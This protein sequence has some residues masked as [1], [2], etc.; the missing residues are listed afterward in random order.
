MNGRERAT[1]QTRRVF[2][3]HSAINTPYGGLLAD[4]RRSLEDVGFIVFV[5]EHEGRYGSDF[6]DRIFAELETCSAAVLLL[7]P[8]AMTSRW[9]TTEINI[10]MA[11]LRNDP[12]RFCVLPVLLG[13]ATLATLRASSVGH[14]HIDNLLMPQQPT[15]P[16]AIV[17]ELADRHPSAGPLQLVEATVAQLLKGIDDELLGAAAA[18]LGVQLRAWHP[19]GKRLAMARA[20][21]TVDERTFTRALLLIRRFL[22]DRGAVVDLVFPFLWV[23]PHAVA[24]LAKAAESLDDRGAFSVNARRART[25]WWYVRRACT[26][27]EGW[28]VVDS[29]GRELED[30]DAG[31]IAEVRDQLVDQVKCDDDVDDDTLRASLKRFEEDYGPIFV[32]L[33]ESVDDRL[34]ASC[35]SRFS[36]VAFL[37]IAGD[38]DGPPLA[39]AELLTPL[40]AR[41]EEDAAH[42]RYL[43]L[44]AQSN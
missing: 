20:M 5:A 35:K 30:F 14:L 17:A 25:G 11:R 1:A 27:P 32:L 34:L 23:N 38:E 21:L 4:L 42:G 37:V 3:S 13:R 31:L 16:D 8:K 12:A 7:S 41:G 43:Q 44:A 10:A 29:V 22:V 19:T 40:I 36:T 15:S 9:C 26:E 24:P 28:K 33:P 6:G 2:I 18:V 39:E